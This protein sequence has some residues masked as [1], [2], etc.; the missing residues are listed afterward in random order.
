M[1]TVAV[2]PEAQVKTP[3]TTPQAPL[4]DFNVKPL[5]LVVAVYVAHVP[6][7]YHVPPLIK[8]PLLAPLVYASRYP[9]PLNPVPGAEVPVGLLVVCKVVGV[10]DPDLGR[11]LT[12]VDGQVD[13]LPSGEVAMK[14]PS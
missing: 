5:P 8:Q 7:T 2:V 12:P 14:V 4:L 9:V 10:V 11:Y 6:P 3:L 13:L 1:K